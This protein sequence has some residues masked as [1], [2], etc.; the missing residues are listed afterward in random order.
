MTATNEEWRPTASISLLIQRA[1]ILHRIRAFF[2]ARHVIE[3]ETPILSHATVTNPHIMSIEAYFKKIGSTENEVCYL[4]TSPEYAM[5]RLLAAGMESIFQ[6]TKSF[7]QGEIGRLHNPEFS[8]LEWYRVGFDHH[9][10]MDELSE[11][12][13]AL[14]FPKAERMS[15]GQVY[16]SYLKI[17]PHSA[18]ISELKDCAAQHIQPL[19]RLTED[20]NSYLDLLFTHCIEPSLGLAAP[21]FIYDFPASQASLAKI[22]QENPPVA[23]RFEL[24]FKGIE[25]ANGF[26]ELQDPDEQRRRFEKELEYRAQHTMPN[27]PIDEHLLDALKHGLP[28]CAG[29]ALGLDRLIMLAL[30]QETIS[31]ILSFGFLNA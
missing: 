8:L 10:L 7:R 23:S 13:L 9:Q 25:L 18:T 31:K 4:Q 30:G 11:L 20:K 6:I 28:D 14:E 2:E 21:L 5:K 22:R 29:V 26:H 12:L 15:V 24:Y 27:I 3:V 1:Q 16:Q 19:P 17:N